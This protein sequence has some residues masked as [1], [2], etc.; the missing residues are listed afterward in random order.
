ML[1]AIL[2]SGLT[3]V[4]FAFI[5]MG[6]WGFYAN[7][8]HGT[9]AALRAGLVQGAASAVLT[10]LLKPSLELMARRLKGSPL[11]RVLPW[12]VST[13]LIATTLTLFH[14]IAGTPNILATIAVPLSV[15][16]T[17]AIVYT[18]TLPAS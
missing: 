2:R 8:D 10:A 1:T 7:S 4:I 3:H 14:L 17:Y 16:T 13:I 18:A 12:I 9:A 15:S 5:V 11:Q 6:A